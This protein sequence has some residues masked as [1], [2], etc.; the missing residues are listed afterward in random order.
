MRRARTTDWSYVGW[1]YKALHVVGHPLHNRIWVRA[2]GLGNLPAEEG[3]L[4]AGNHTS[5]WDP[6]V[7]ELTTPRPVN[8]LAKKEMMSSAFNRWFFFDKGGCIPVDRNARNPEAFAAAAQALRDGRIIGIF[9]EG[10]RFVGELGPFK[11]GVAR[12]AM[13][14]GAP[15]VPVAIATDRFWPTGRTFPRLG[16][17]VY[18]NAGAPIRLAGDPHDADA[19]KAGTDRVRAAIDALLKEA[20]AARD[21]K[22]KWA[23]P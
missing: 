13:E 6:I 14:A 12:L 23:A 5:W 16:Q 4:Y 2:K 1:H 11:T 8:W 9:P 17:R 3:F 10:T 22:A 20:R 21:A 7:L 19:V 15:I 18:L